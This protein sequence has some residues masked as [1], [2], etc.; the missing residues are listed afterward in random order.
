[1]RGVNDSRFGDFGS[2]RELLDAAV[3]LF[4]IDPDIRRSHDPDADFV[5]LDGGDHDLDVA[6]DDD[7]FA[8][9]AS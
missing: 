1:L 7:L 3:D 6:A 5:A 2:F 9:F 4:A 8:D